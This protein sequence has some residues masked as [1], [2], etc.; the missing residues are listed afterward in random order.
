[1]RG[2]LKGMFN[3]K[4]H[5]TDIMVGNKESMSSVSKGNFKGQVMQ[6]YGYYF[7]VTLQDVLLYQ[8]LMVH[9]FSLTKAIDTKG[10]HLSIKGQIITLQI[11]RNKI[12]FDTIFK[13]GSD[14]L[15]GS[16]IHH[17]PN[18]IAATAQTWTSTSYTQWLIIPILKV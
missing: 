15:L 7:E 2:S 18:H 13:H 4:S 8:Q 16:E 3:L 5:V 14:Q 12:Y 17:N 10:V 1:M 6:K 11:V 9:L